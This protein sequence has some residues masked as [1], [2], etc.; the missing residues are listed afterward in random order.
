MVYMASTVP[1]APCVGKA[2]DGV[3]VGR[4]IRYGGWSRFRQTA[5]IRRAAPADHNR[6]QCCCGGR[7]GCAARPAAGRKS[8]AAGSRCTRRARHAAGGFNRDAGYFLGSIYFNYG[9]TGDAGHR[10]VLRHVFR[11]RA[12]RTTSGWRCSACLSSCFRCGFFVT[13]GRCGSHSDE[14][15]DPWPNEEETRRMQQGAG[16]TEQGARSEQYQ[17]LGTQYGVWQKDA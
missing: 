9:V 4:P 15:W 12:W 11:R 13:P 17:V 10:D 6:W 16:S 8:F 3:G 14:Y 7:C 5:P 1:P 2:R